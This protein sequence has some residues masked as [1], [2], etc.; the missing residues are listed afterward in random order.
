MTFLL[1]RDVPEDI[2]YSLHTLGH[3]IVRLREVMA[4]EAGDSE[5]LA[6]A[7]Q[8]EAVLITCNRDDFLELARSQRHSGIIILIRRRTRVAERTA[9]VRLLD[10]AG[11][12]GIMDN[13]NFA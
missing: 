4:K 6:Y 10:Q 5:V 8:S 2:T 3:R 7:I 1:D 11:E 13:I 12:S 9:L